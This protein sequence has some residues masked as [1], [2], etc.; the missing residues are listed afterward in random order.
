MDAASNDEDANVGHAVE[1]M[2][3]APAVKRYVKLDIVL[4]AMTG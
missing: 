3:Y 1:N 4:V 2:W